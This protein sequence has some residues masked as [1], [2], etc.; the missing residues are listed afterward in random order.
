MRALV[1]LISLK[2]VQFSKKLTN[3]NLVE[4]EIEQEASHFATSKGL[5]FRRTAIKINN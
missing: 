2:Y 4:V 1:I 5:L 3:Y